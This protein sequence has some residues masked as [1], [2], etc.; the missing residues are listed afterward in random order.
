MQDQ[1]Q[2][3]ITQL[4]NNKNTIA[5]K[6]E[7]SDFVFICRIADPI[8]DFLVINFSDRT[9]SF[10]MLPSGFLKRGGQPRHKETI[11]SRE[12]DRVIRPLINEPKLVDIYTVSRD[13]HLS[14]DKMVKY[15]LQG[16]SE[17]LLLKKYIDEPLNII[18][19]EIPGVNFGVVTLYKNF[20]IGLSIQSNGVNYKD[21]V[22]Y[23]KKNTRDFNN[24]GWK[25]QGIEEKIQ[26][27]GNY[28]QVCK[29]IMDYILD[30]GRQND[31][32]Y[33]LN[34]YPNYYDGMKV[35]YLEKLQTNR[36][37]GRKGLREI[38][39]RII[40]KDSFPGIK[41][42]FSIIGHVGAPT[43]ESYSKG[44][45]IR[46][47]ISSNPLNTSQILDSTDYDEKYDDFIIHYYNMGLSHDEF[48]AKRVSKRELGHAQLVKSSLSNFSSVDG[49]VVSMDFEVLVPN[50]GTSMFS[51]TL[52]SILLYNA[53]LKD[54]VITGSSSGMI[55]KDGNVHR[56]SDITYTEDLFGMCDVK[57]SSQGDNIYAS[58]ADFK[59][60]QSLHISILEE[61]ISMS[62]EDN[63][64]IYNQISEYLD[65]SINLPIPKVYIYKTK[66]SK[67]IGKFIGKGG[68]NIKDFTSKFNLTVD[69]EEL[70][71]KIYSEGELSSDCIKE[72]KRLE[73]NKD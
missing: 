30:T 59:D 18:L 16:V 72:L 1:K 3:I 6:I 47:S 71:L 69:V 37:G 46:A 39:S 67:N 23:I 5:L 50:G 40:E 8:K 2:P 13:K 49:T 10:G 29:T 33:F 4:I 17:I 19:L 9:Q 45:V 43:T 7:Y 41:N 48:I 62:I 26:E 51:T 66:D 65:R 21:V 53:G 42:K 31:V 24:L 27:G 70:S 25:Y 11:L 55:L 32:N 36:V 35:V 52:G 54:I 28:F 22:E 64:K 61:F 14:N 57:I 58:Q 34:L 68:S 56:I 44:M 12:I 73:F 38:R 60:I 15:I 20:V 63:K